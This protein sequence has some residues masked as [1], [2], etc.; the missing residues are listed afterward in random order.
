MVFLLG[1][2]IHRVASLRH[3]AVP[4]DPRLS[5]RIYLPDLYIAMRDVNT[6]PAHMNICKQMPIYL[7]ISD[8]Q[9]HKQMKLLITCYI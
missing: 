8:D 5:F 1:E 9:Q 3:H 2:L 4:I 7:D 6:W